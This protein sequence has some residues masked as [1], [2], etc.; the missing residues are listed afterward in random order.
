MRAWD[1]TGETLDKRIREAINTAMSRM[2]SDVPEALLPDEQHVVLHRDITSGVDGVYAQVETDSRVVELIDSAGLAI[3]DGSSV[4]AVRPSLLG[5]WDGVMH[6]E[7]KD[8]AGNW[9]RRQSREWF[10]DTSGLTPKHLVTIDRPWPK[11]NEGTGTASSN[12]APMQLRIYQPEFFLS[13]DVSRLLEPMRVYDSSRRQVWG[14]D[15]GGASRFDLPDFQGNATG[16]PMRFWRGRHFQIQAPTEAPTVANVFNPNETNSAYTWRSSNLKGG[17]FRLCYTYVWGRRDLE[18]QQAPGIHVNAKTPYDG[19]DKLWW[20]FDGT[21]G[22][23]EVTQSKG[24]TDPIWESAPSPVTEFAAIGDLSMTIQATNIDAMLGFHIS[25]SAAYPRHGRSGFRLRFYIGQ[26]L[27]SNFGSTKGEYRNVETSERMYLL[28]EVDPTFDQLAGTSY[29]ASGG[30]CRFL[31]G[32]QLYDYYRPLK[33]STGYYAYKVY[34]HQDARY[35]MD[36]RALRVPP[37]LIDNQDTPPIARDG[38]P[39]LLELSLYYVC[40]LDGVDQAN[41][42]VHLNEYEKLVKTFRRNHGNPGGAVEPMSLYGRSSR[43]NRYGTF[44]SG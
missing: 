2:S 42:Q 27:V 13:D 26:T 5:D 23:G 22:S 10:R 14:I 9:H 37:R 20:S 6:L 17:E 36:L 24:I 34:P 39:A 29:S 43:F 11:P 16:R 21:T 28:C 38:I 4:T 15:T 40:L 1:S 7:I 19:T 25:T 31:W 35:E 8:A 32:G 33:H 3:E 41:A 44:D 12:N 18:W 30:P